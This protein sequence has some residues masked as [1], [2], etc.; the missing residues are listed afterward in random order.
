MLSQHHGTFVK[1]K[2]LP[3]LEL[4]QTPPPSLP[5]LANKDKASTCHTERRK[6]NAEG[7]R[8]R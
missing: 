2:L 3:S 8:K 1:T 4:A 5:V 7:G 6:A